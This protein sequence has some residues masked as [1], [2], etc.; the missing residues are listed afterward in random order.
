MILALVVSVLIQF[1]ADGKQ[2][3]TVISGVALD[4]VG[5]DVNVKFCGLWSN[6]SCVM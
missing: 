4:E 2:L 1:A 5:L 6:C 3:V